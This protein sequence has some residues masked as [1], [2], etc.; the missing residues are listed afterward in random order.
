MYLSNYILKFHERELLCPAFAH[1]GDGSSS[2]YLQHRTRILK[3]TLHMSNA[4]AEHAY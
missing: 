4:D 2:R 1:I 3:K